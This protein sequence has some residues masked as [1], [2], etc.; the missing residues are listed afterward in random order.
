V[1]GLKMRERSAERRRSVFVYERDH[2][3]QPMSITAPTELS[4]SLDRILN[5]LH[6]CGT[7]TSVTVGLYSAQ[8]PLAK[9]SSAVAALLPFFIRPPRTGISR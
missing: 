8:E 6:R 1:I 3:K 4:N 7:V 2:K 9:G 5:A